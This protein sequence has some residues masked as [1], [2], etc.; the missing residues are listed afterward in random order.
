MPIGRASLQKP[1]PAIDTVQLWVW[2]I[3]PRPVSRSMMTI[4]RESVSSRSGLRSGFSKSRPSPLSGPA[5]SPG[6]NRSITRM[7]WP[8]A[9]G[10]WK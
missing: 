6:M 5:F 8:G 3:T 10:T 2:T 9:G 7:P 4:T 1:A